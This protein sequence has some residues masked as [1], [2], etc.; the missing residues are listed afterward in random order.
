MAE[1]FRVLRPQEYHSQLV[2]KGQ[3]ADG[4]KLEE[5]RDVKLETDAI[6]TA[7]SSSLV[8]LGNT[9]LVCGV[10]SQV[11]KY[12]SKGKECEEIK[13]RLELPPICSSP[14]GHRTQN[15]A[16][17]LTKT[18]KN[19]LEKSDC[20]DTKSFHI[21]ELDLYWC[22]DV[23]VICLNYDGSIIDAAL[24]AILSALKTLKLTSQFSNIESRQIKLNNV[25]ICSSF[26]MIGNRIICDPNLEEEIV[27]QTT[28]SITLEPQ[29]GQTCHINK[30]G[31]KALTKNQLF[32]C[33]EL[34]KKRAIELEQIINTENSGT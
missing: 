7:D 2:L 28:F 29:T 9:S 8:K 11:L 19:I 3:R 5:P 22:I 14:T 12:P 18:L 21:D 20:L 6:R 27:A 34:A 26:A 10:T 15:T 17:L 33:I 4:R 32:K 16:Q 30:V 23:E 25:P 1:E 24:I 31:G 13:I